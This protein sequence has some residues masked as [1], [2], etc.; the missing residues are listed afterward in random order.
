MA[1]KVYGGSGDKRKPLENAGLGVEDE[2]DQ[3][4]PR[5]YLIL[6]FEDEPRG[7]GPR[8]YEIIIQSSSFQDL[9]EGMIRA[10][11]EA[12]IKAFGAALMADTSQGYWRPK[13]T[14]NPA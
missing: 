7:F 12:A 4:C 6:G 14:A 8:Q 11:R 10:D 1:L 3:K 13:R 2:G 9:A 5:C